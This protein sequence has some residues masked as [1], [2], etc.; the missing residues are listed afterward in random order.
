MVEQNFKTYWINIHHLFTL[1]YKNG[2]CV[3]I[4]IALLRLL[5]DKKGKKASPRVSKTGIEVAAAM[6]VLSKYQ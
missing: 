6:P 3:H 4:I 2:F 1:I 5:L